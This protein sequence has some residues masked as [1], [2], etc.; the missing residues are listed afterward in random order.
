MLEPL[1]SADRPTPWKTHYQKGTKSVKPF[2]LY[3]DIPTAIVRRELSAHGII[4]EEIF[5]GGMRNA[6]AF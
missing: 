3:N 5:Y 6:T 1:C 2:R 4:Q